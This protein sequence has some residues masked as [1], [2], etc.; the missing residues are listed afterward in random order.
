MNK[1]EQLGYWKQYYK[2]HREARLIQAKAA[3][4]AVKEIRS[5]IYA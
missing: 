2:D 1:K 3:M 5:A 4:L